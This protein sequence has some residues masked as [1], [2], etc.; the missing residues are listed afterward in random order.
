MIFNQE[1]YLKKGQIKSQI[2]P[3]NEKYSLRI[4]ITGLINSK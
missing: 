4:L 2:I 3:K 1:N